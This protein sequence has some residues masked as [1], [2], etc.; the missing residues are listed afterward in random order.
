MAQSPPRSPSELLSMVLDKIDMPT[1]RLD[2]VE[3]S[4]EPQLI[5]YSTMLY[6]SEAPTGAVEHVATIRFTT[7]E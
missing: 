2:R 4:A 5:R 7:F 3:Y 6:D 1:T